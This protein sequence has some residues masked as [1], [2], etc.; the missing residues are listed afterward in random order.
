VDTRCYYCNKKIKIKNFILNHKYVCK[1][2]KDGNGKRIA[3]RYGNGEPVK[4][5]ATEYNMSVNRVRNVIT[6]Q[7]IEIKAY[8]IKPIKPLVPKD[9]LIGTLM[10]WICKRC[11]SKFEYEYQGA[12]K[13]LCPNCR[14]YKAPRWDTDW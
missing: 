2:C 3:E 13:Q 10:T 5:L 14:S 4:I 6:K 7:G 11:N 9:T 12:Y 8:Y 1:E